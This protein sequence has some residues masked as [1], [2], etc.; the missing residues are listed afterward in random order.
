MSEKFDAGEILKKISFP[1]CLTQTGITLHQKAV[2]YAY[3]LFCETISLLQKQKDLPTLQA[4]DE[5]KARY[6]DKS[7]PY[8]ARISWEWDARFIE[9][10]VRAMLFENV[11][12]PYAVYNGQKI[13]IAKAFVCLNAEDSAPCGTIVKKTKSCVYVTTGNGLLRVR[14]SDIGMQDTL[15]DE[16][17]L[18]TRFEV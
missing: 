7:I 16:L 18:G 15:F 11:L 6:Y 4:Q 12:P 17:A 14:K 13:H 9:K 5:S 1:V 2:R 3:R 10:Y 8:G